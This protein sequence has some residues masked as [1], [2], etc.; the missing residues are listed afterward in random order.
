MILPFRADAKLDS[1]PVLLMYGSVPVYRRLSTSTTDGPDVR[2]LERPDV[3]QLERNLVALGFG[4]GV[5]V[6]EHFS[7][8]TAAAQAL[9]R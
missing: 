9:P 1:R 4:S 5:P 3:R 7:A 2:Q 8:A 6:D